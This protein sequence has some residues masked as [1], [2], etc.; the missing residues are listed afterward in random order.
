[1]IKE[2][3]KEHLIN[4]NNGIIKINRSGKIIIIPSK[5]SR[6]ILNYIHFFTKNCRDVLTERIYWIVNDI[7]EYPCCKQ[8][9][10]KYSSNFYGFKRGYVGKSFCSY[11]CMGVNIEVREKFSETEK[12]KL[13]KNPLMYSERAKKTKE[14][15]I[16][17]YGEHYMSSEERKIRSID[18][19]GVEHPM[20]HDQVVSNLEKSI[21][22][23]YGVNN[24]A[25]TDEFSQKRKSTNLEKYGVEYP[26]QNE[27]SLIK[28]QK[29]RIKTEQL[30]TGEIIQFQGYENVAIKELLKS[31][32]IME[33]NFNRKNIPHILYYNQISN[34]T[35]R[36]FPDIFIPKLNK[37]IEV[38]SEWTFGHLN[39]NPH[40]L[41]VN[42]IKFKT[43][44]EQGFSFEFWICNKNKII[45]ILTSKAEISSYL[46][47]SV[48]NDMADIDFSKI[49]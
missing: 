27:Q 17:K 2:D 38:K 43:C 24:Y 36:Y 47:S 41:K 18:K 49:W 5:I 34:S 32:S 29:R 20:K 26:M 48:K 42:L 13:E 4:P 19:Y 15:M 14:T 21:F 7:T 11:K 10:K 37:I 33:I 25:K 12:E 16:T 45:Q 3:L 39:P 40:D 31:F 6:D 9:G 1:M 30:L 22:L 28:N 44:L 35:K 8:C 46:A 23:K